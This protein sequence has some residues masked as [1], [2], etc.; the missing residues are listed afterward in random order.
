MALALLALIWIEPFLALTLTTLQHFRQLKTQKLYM[1][2]DGR[3]KKVRTVSRGEPCLMYETSLSRMIMQL[4]PAQMANQD[5]DAGMETMLWDINISPNEL[6]NGYLMLPPGVLHMSA[7]GRF[8]RFTLFSPRVSHSKHLP[9]FCFVLC[10]VLGLGVFVALWCFC[11]LFCKYLESRILR[12][13]LTS[14]T[15]KALSLVRL[16]SKKKGQPGAEEGGADVLEIAIR[17]PR[18]L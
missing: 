13:V 14:M 15:D 11:F 5:G 12:A 10:C 16:C 6:D 8:G 1:H 7:L 17:F 18:I 4:P 2:V 9:V 3:P